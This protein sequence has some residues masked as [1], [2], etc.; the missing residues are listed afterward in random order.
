MLVLRKSID[1]MASG[2]A[3]NIINR[4]RVMEKKA[5]PLNRRCKTLRIEELGVRVADSQLF[6]PV[7]FISVGVFPI[8]QPPV[9]LATG[10]RAGRNHNVAICR[11]PAEVR[12]LSAAADREANAACQHDDTGV[13]ICARRAE[14]TRRRASLL[15]NIAIR[16]MLAKR[17]HVSTA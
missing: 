3:Q 11:M 10:C 8:S 5:T 13:V 2:C 14:A 7:E 6:D 1:S 16:R 12:H 4:L 17:L 15:H 9:A